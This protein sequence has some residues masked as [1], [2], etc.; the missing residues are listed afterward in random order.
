M[1]LLVRWL[2]YVSLL[3]MFLPVSAGFILAAID[4]QV[5]L[6]MSSWPFLSVVMAGFIGFFVAIA[7]SNLVICKACGRKA[8]IVPDPDEPG[9]F[10]HPWRRR[11]SHCS[12]PLA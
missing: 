10:H 9:G 7:L 6:D 1:Y 3:A 11:C 5:L 8:H 2:C 12:A 4:L